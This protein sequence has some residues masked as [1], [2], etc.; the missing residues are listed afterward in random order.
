MRR[1]RKLKRAL[2]ALKRTLG[3]AR[4]SR[5]RLGPHAL[6]ITIWIMV[7]CAILSALFGIFWPNAIAWSPSGK[8][9]SEMQITA[10]S[11]SRRALLLVSAGAIGVATLFHSFRKLDFEART[12]NDTHSLEVDSNF[13]A[14]YESCIKQ[15][16]ST[17][18]AE[19]MGGIYA[20]ERLAADSKREA[21]LARKVL[22]AFL[23]QNWSIAELPHDA[24]PKEGG[25]R[26]IARRNRVAR[27][28]VGLAAFH[29]L[30]S[31][32]GSEPLDLRQINF[33]Q[34]DASGIQ[35]PGA[36]FG[37]CSLRGS[38]LRG[39]NF[40]GANFSYSD[41]QG[42]DLTSADISEA[43]FRNTKLQ[44]ALL[45]R[46]DASGAYFRAAQMARCQMRAMLGRGA[47]FKTAR[48]ANAS[49]RN[50][51]LQ[52]ASLISARLSE[53]E[54]SGAH[55]YGAKLTNALE[56]SDAQFE[57]ARSWNQ[58]TIWPNGYR[59]NQ[60]NKLEPNPAGDTVHESSGSTSEWTTS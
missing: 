46:A 4:I 12:H 13:T 6:S 40:H 23:R 17:Q 1:D 33:G 47:N 22:A 56:W 2:N 41:L 39:A 60:L 49:L 35:L 52:N 5:L 8:L 36:N 51:K 31:I 15:L 55:L 27:S 21:V 20:L 26:M 25:G 16:A 44:N 57:S 11:E 43:G 9:T 24:N 29:A 3:Q 28:T 53:T 59:P 19:Q 58:A 54:F 48:M 42:V 30:T 14:R 45:N 37:G 38:K 10:T 7:I 34:I 50:A 18:V 32:P